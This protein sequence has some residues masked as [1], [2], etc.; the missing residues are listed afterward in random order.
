[1]IRKAVV[2][3][4]LAALAVLTACGSTPTT[5]PVQTQVHVCQQM[6]TASPSPTNRAAYD[7]QLAKWQ[8][9]AGE[10]TLGTLLQTLRT[11]MKQGTGSFAVLDQINQYCL[12]LGV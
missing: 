2:A 7:A 1:M 8:K 3:V 6:N 4:A 9:E 11:D 10:T 5:N 12:K